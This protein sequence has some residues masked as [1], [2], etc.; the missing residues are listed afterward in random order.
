MATDKPVARF[1]GLTSA[2]FSHTVAG[3]SSRGEKNAKAPSDLFT[4]SRTSVK[5]A[6]LIALR[7]SPLKRANSFPISLFT[8]HSP[9]FLLHPFL[10]TLALLVAF[11]YING[12]KSDERMK[13]PL[14]LQ[15]EFV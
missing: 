5:S 15:R 6:G 8:L 13:A 11:G 1:N 14:V 9:L 10:F 3:G 4:A 7:A 2:G 12:G